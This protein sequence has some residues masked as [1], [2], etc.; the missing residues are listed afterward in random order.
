MQPQKKHEAM[1]KMQQVEIHFM[2]R[3]SPPKY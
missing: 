1:K 2:M 3:L